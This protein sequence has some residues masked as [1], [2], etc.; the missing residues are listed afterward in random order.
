MKTMFKKV[1][2]PA[3]TL[4]ELVITIVVIG[5][6]AAALVATYADLSDSAKNGAQKAS[7]SALQTQIAILLAKN[8]GV[9]PTGNELA[10]ANPNMSYSG[11]GFVV[12]DG[13]NPPNS[14]F[15]IATF[16]DS[17]CTKATSDLMDKVACVK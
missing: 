11:S 9:L 13:A 10:A 5:I 16:T 12:T 15:K 8:N 3:F 17:A 6:L 4:I 2:R 7:I 14:L 1:M